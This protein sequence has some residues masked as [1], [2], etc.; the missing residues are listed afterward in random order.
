[1]SELSFDVIISDIAE[2]DLEAL[3]DYVTETRSSDVAVELLD[4]IQEVVDTLRAFPQRGSC[5]IEFQGVGESEIRQLLQW[6]YRVIYAINGSVVEV[7]A[8]VDGRRN[9]R[10][11]LQSRL[12]NR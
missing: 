11:L 1:M 6:P 4:K 5:P 12:A 2:R 3:Y 8:V 10:T 7:F 9:M